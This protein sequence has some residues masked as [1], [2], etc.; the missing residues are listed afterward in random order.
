MGHRRW[1]PPN[2]TYRRQKGQFDGTQETEEAPKTMSGTSV[3]QCYKAE[4]L[5]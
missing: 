5:C 1:L 2:H 4:S 3:L